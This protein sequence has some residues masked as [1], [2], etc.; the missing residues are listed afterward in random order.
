MN[1]IQKVDLN[2]PEIFDE[3]IK[4]L[5]IGFNNSGY[6]LFDI[7]NSFYQEMYSI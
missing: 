2:I 3:K 7:N 5:Y 6:D 4:Y 1:K